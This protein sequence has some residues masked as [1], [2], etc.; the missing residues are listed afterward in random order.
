[1]KRTYKILH[2]EDIASDAEL[3]ER[4]LKKSGLAFNKVIVDKKND[5]TR[6]LQDFQPDIV[7]SDHSLP[8]FNSLEALKILKSSGKNIPFILITATVSEE[9][10]VD[11][12]KEGASDYVLKD[13]LQRLPSAVTNAIQKY[14]LD[15]ERNTYLNKIVA[16][17]ALFTKAESIAEFGTWRYNINTK[18]INWSSGTYHLLGYKHKEVEPSIH[19]FLKRVVP[20]DLPKLEKIFKE[21]LSKLHHGDV[22]FR[23]K[24]KDRSIRYIHS[25]FEIEMDEEDKPGYITGFNQDVTSTKK[26]E[27]NIQRSI[28]ELTAAAERQSAILNA[29]PP[30]VVLLNQT[31]KIVAVNDSWRKF[32]LDN[33]LGIPKYG[34]DYS[35]TAISEKALGIDRASGKKIA[36]G[37]KEVIAGTKNEFSMEYPCHSKKKSVWFQIIIVPLTDKTKKGAVVLHIDITDRK[38]AEESMQQSQANLQ[39]IFE[40]TDIAYVLCNARQKIVSFNSKADEFALL[41]FDKKLKVG[42]SAFGY[43]PKSKIPNLKDAVKRIANNEMV[44]YE[45]SYMLKDGTVK[46]YDVRW[47]GVA[48]EKKENIGFILSFKDSTA[49]K[50]TELE[51]EKMNADLVQRNTDLEQFTYIVSHNFRAPVAN[52]L[53]LTNILNNYDLDVSENEEVKAALTVSINNLDQIIMDMNHILQVSSRINDKTE[54]VS[55]R[56]LVEEITLSLSNLI[57]AEHAIVSLNCDAADSFIAIKSY[58][59]SIFYNLILNGI[60]YKRAGV[61]P[62]VSI[63]TRKN[64]DKLEIIFRDNGKGIEE[65]NMKELFGLY[66]RFDNN[67]E[68]KGLGLFMVKMQVQK[69]GGKIHVQSRPGSGTTFK[70]EFPVLGLAI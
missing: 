38:K 52:I 25:Q 56:P 17:E 44:S 46:W 51:R 16:S 33:N 5:Y 66:K 30:N 7:L 43:F 62:I 12:M 26:A 67:V 47:V 3:V 4:T 34:I 37:I 41:Q 22:E 10:A 58:M 20:E 13:R 65:K 28:D 21:P 59:H 70:L 45:T 48:N 24:N 15:N 39:T 23:I 36:S 40:N 32:T 9:F 6:L 49:R 42:N 50:I 53:G 54:V 14:R 57:Q 35:Y 55:F 60:K 69:L 8:T 31:G 61:N 1:M 63:T 2:I 19:N 11:I 27:I 68:G 18:K 29:L 64:Y